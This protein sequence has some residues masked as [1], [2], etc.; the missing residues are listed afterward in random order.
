MVRH[1]SFVSRFLPLINCA[2]AD[3]YSNILLLLLTMMLR[4]SKKGRS[5]PPIH[6]SRVSTRLKR[7]LTP[8]IGAHP[9]IVSPGESGK[10]KASVVAPPSPFQ[11]EDLELSSPLLKPLDETD[12][13]QLYEWDDLDI[14]K[15]L[16]A[17]ELEERELGLKPAGADCRDTTVAYSR[18]ASRV[19][20]DFITHLDNVRAYEE[21]TVRVKN[22]FHT[23]YI[24]ETVPTVIPKV[25]VDLSGLV[26]F[27]KIRL[28]NR[29]VCSWQSDFK[30]KVPNSETKCPFYQPASQNNLL[31]VF[32]S[33]MNRR[34]G[35]VIGLHELT[36]FT[37]CLTAMLANLYSERKKI[38]VSYC[39]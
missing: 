1:V 39:F 33:A 21:L 32:F 18:T 5:V 14:S 17:L 38:W 11:P 35:W 19:I 15:F 12:S 9:A 29:L 36:G 37:G 24:D 16:D 31:R 13:A 27:G 2:F 26:S 20:T 25:F 6:Q 7:S 34:F 4:S 3:L 22:P 8:V 30:M 10:V 28:V 23:G